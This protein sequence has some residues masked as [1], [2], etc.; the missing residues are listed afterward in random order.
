[1]SLHLKCMCAEPDY[2]F[3][4]DCHCTVRFPH[5]KQEVTEHR[6]LSP[7]PRARTGGREQMFPVAVTQ[8]R[9]LITRALGDILSFLP[10]CF[11][12]AGGITLEGYSKQKT[13][14]YILNSL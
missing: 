7:H 6:K 5:D 10:L 8:E 3:L 14:S 1:M 4:P 13:S 11:S 12:L 9:S 2:L